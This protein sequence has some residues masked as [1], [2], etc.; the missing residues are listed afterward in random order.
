MK[1]KNQISNIQFGEILVRYSIVLILLWIGALKFTTYEAEGIKG[2]V[3]N[4]PFLSWGYSIM[5]IQGFSQFIGIIEIILAIL[6]AL[7]YHS[8]KL[9]AIGSYG[10]VIMSLVTLS[11][12]FT[13]PIWKSD[14][15]FP[16]LS[17]SG[18]FIVKDILL[19]SAAFWTASEAKNAIL[20]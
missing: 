9:S 2:L 1:N 20:I 11:F 3:E 10:A 8:P 4:S 18:Q 14:M 6:I 13:T 19:L 12:L 16:F 7:R 5:S 17:S 15:G